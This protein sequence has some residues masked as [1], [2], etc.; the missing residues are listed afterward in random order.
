MK[1]VLFICVY[2][3]ARSQLAEGLARYLGKG[4]I[5]AYSAGLHE[6]GVN[7]YAIEVMKEIGI[8]ISSQRSKSVQEYI[9][10]EFDY[11]I[12]LCSEAEGTCPVFPGNAVVMHWPLRDPNTMGETRE[13]KLE[14]FRLARD[15]IFKRI[16][17]LLKDIL[18]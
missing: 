10:G 18:D 17:E 4:R 12:T 2:N 9:D 16:N 5:E 14:A 6:T 13:Q 7:P 11:V 1:S 3:S 15:D 8:D